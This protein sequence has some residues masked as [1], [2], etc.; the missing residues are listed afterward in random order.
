MAMINGNGWTCIKTEMDPCLFF[1]KLK[2]KGKPTLLAWALVHTDDVDI[3]GT[4][5]EIIQAIFDALH[6]KGESKLLIL[7]PCLV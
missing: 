5:T 2:I 4:T 3:V 7:L 1:F 6:K